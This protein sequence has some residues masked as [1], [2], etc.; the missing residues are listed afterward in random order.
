MLSTAYCRDKQSLK[1]DLDL[2]LLQIPKPVTKI[3][4]YILVLFLRTV[5]VCFCSL[6]GIFVVF[7]AFN[8][9][10]Q[11]SDQ[12]KTDGGLFL[13]MIRYYG[14]YMLL[15]FD[16]TGA[17]ITLMAFL[18]TAGWLRRTGE[19]TATLA[20]GVSH[21]RILR[22]MIVAAVF[23]IFAQLANRELLVPQFR[24]ALTMKKNELDKTAEQ[25]VQPRNDHINAIVL[26]GRSLNAHTKSITQPNFH[27]DGD[28]QG[29]GDM[30]SATKAVWMDSDGARPSGYLM[31]DVQ[32]P[33]QIDELPSL[34]AQG[35]PVLMTSRDQDWLSSGECFVATTV[36]IDLLQTN[37]AATRLASVA[38]LAERVRNPAVHSSA[39]LKVLLHERIVRVPLDISLILLGLPL[40]VNRRGKGLFVLIGIAIGTVLTFFAL[41]TLAGTMGSNSYMVTPGMAAWIPL[42]IL[43][44]IAFVRYRDVQT[45]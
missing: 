34:G 42:L 1:R 26:E 43:G 12:G 10:N 24:D 6:A 45:V 18:F 28:Y 3:D 20:A 32:L 19:L 11:L 40:V 35:R 31:T 30:L 15:L 21:G 13:V 27:L 2:F 29:Y 23:I 38:E 4:R 8:N 44:P 33:E 22:P 17:I 41:K 16:M 25:S 37:E 39:G 5:F 7:H 36:N 9:I 14:P